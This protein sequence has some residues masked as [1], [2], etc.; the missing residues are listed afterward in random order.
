[1]CIRDRNWPDGIDY[2]LP[3]NKEL[4]IRSSE[5]SVV[6]QVA[7]GG[8]EGIYLDIYLDGSI[9]VYKRQARNTTG[10]RYCSIW[11]S[12]IWMKHRLLACGAL[13][14]KRIMPVCGSK[15]IWRKR[16]I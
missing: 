8:S 3:E 12:W 5:F 9:D 14:R 10:F 7:Y 11:P 16:L 15:G 4:E 1:M 6:S 2:A 13:M